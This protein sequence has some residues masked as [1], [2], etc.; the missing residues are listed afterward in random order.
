M[1]DT[2]IE[3]YSAEEWD[4]LRKRFEG[5]ALN[6]TEIAILGQNAGYSWPFR[7]SDETP[8][9][10]IGFTF[11]EL[12]SVPG[13]VRKKSRVRRLMDILRETLAFDDPFSDLVDSVEL[14]GL[15]DH[16]FERILIKYNISP[17]YPAELVNFTETTFVLLKEYAPVTLLDIIRFIQRMPQNSREGEEL[18]A[19]LNCIALM[20]ESG[21]AR[22]LPYRRGDRGLY[23]PEEI[24]LIAQNLSEPVQL[25]LVQQSGTELTEAE[26][27]ILETG[28][29]LESKAELKEA[30]ETMAKACAWFVEE[31][32]FLKSVFTGE[33]DPH[34][35][36]IPIQNPDV[37]RIAVAL[38]RVHFGYSEKD[39]GGLIGRISGMFKR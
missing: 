31:A 6:D 36:F 17:E 22:Y 1:S 27:T 21:M 18:R 35:Y 28:M 15:E 29:G 5:S 7:G 20:D 37:E 19:F 39:R 24:G 32:A 9:K 11:E 2:S 4:S 25:A 26:S 30:V 33:T 13:L 34:R 38:A 16:T 23:L 12:D 14:D 3:P 10:Y 8:L